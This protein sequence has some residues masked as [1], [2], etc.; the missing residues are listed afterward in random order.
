MQVEFYLIDSLKII[1][2]IQD[3]G[4]TLNKIWEIIDEETRDEVN[5]VVDPIVYETFAPKYHIKK[6]IPSKTKREWRKKVRRW[7]NKE[8]LDCTKLNQQTV[9]NKAKRNGGGG[10]Q[11]I[12]DKD[13]EYKLYKQFN[14]ACLNGNNIHM[15]I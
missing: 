15:M 14:E 12:I 8:S 1:K 7:A 5:K 10:R 3:A 4:L 13:V 6:A 9:G 2:K 11:Q